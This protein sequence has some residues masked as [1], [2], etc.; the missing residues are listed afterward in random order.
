MISLSFLSNYEFKH[1]LRATP[2][3]GSGV[4]IMCRS[5]LSTAMIK[6]ETSGLYSNFEH[7]EL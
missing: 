3:P 1:V 7:I 2:R 5:G 6:S 4:G